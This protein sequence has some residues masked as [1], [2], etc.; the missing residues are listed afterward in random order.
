M[1]LCIRVRIFLTHRSGRVRATICPDILRQSIGDMTLS[2]TPRFIT[3]RES[4][5]D[6]LSAIGYRSRVNFTKLLISRSERAER[7]RQL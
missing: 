2:E 5:Y 3:P 6:L 1:S 4:I 7:W